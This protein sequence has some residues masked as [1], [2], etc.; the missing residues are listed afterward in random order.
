MMVCNSCKFKP[1]IDG[2]LRQ[3]PC[4]S[5]IHNPGFMDHYKEELKRCPFC[6]NEARIVTD[7]D[8]NNHY[9]YLVE[10][11]GDKCG[12]STPWC[13]TKEEAYERWNRRGILK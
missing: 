7:C 10:C 6:D 1:I 5:C 13:D 8:D 4:S 12:A 3:F 9:S 11:I 2:S